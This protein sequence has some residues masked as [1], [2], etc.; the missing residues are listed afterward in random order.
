MIE[1]K[2]ILYVRD[3]SLIG[4]VESFVYEMV[5]KYHGLDIAVVC[6]QIEINQLRRLSKYCQV[7]KHYGEQIKCDVAI[8]NYDTSIIPYINEDAK[9]YQVIHG[10]YSDPA[11]KCKPPTDPRVYKYIAIT[12]H[13]QNNWE[14]LTGYSNVMLGYNPLTIEDKEP[15]VLVSATRL[16]RV[17]GKERMQKLAQALDKARVNYIWYIFTTDKDVEFSPNCIYMKPRLDVN[18]WI[19]KADYLVQL[20]DTEGLSY[21][22]NEA[23]YRNIPVIVTPLPYLKEIGVED[24]K[25]AYILDFSCS[26]VDEIAKKITNK[27]KFEFKKLSDPYDKILKKSTNNFILNKNKLVKV[28]ITTSYTDMKLNRFIQKDTIL[29]VDKDRANELINARVGEAI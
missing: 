22:I 18:K 8:I 14:K 15:L 9:I 26:N 5:K 25:N 20:S 4:G 13:I 29:E 1:H 28:L 19:A 24:G 2:N 10:D 12:K 23:L 3:I 21:S 16:S 17:K 27:P 11:Y 6:K 7:Y